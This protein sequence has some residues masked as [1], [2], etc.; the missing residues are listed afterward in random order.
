MSLNFI[1]KSIKSF[2]L[3]GV[4]SL[5]IMAWMDYLS[6]LWKSKLIG[7]IYS[8]NIDLELVPLKKVTIFS[9]SSHE[10]SFYFHGAEENERSHLILKVMLIFYRNILNFLFEL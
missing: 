2:V 9:L 7:F 5:V 8:Q 1:L 10:F 4:A 6:F 3:L